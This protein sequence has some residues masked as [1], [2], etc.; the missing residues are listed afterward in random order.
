MDNQK[1]FS[2]T[3]IKDLLIIESLIRT[4]YESP[5]TARKIQDDVEKQWNRLFPNEPLEKN[6]GLKTIHKHVRD[7]NLLRGLYNIKA[8]TDNKL[9]YYNT[10]HLLTPAEV[11]VIGAAIYNITS[12]TDDE[13]KIIF[14]EI[15]SATNNAGYSIAYGFERQLSLENNPQ[16]K[17]SKVILPK[18]ERICKA[19]VEGKKITF[20]LKRN[21]ITD[22]ESQ[23]TASPYSILE[24]DNEIFLTAKVDSSPKP[25]DFR[26]TFMSKIEILA[27]DFNSDKKF[28][29]ARHLSGINKDA[30]QIELRISFP[31][32]LIE[33]VYKRFDKNKK[34]VCRPNGKKI[35]DEYQYVITITVGEDEN[36]YQW[37]RQH[38]DKV[39]VISPDNVKQSLKEQL[40]KALSTL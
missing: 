10:K 16:K 5:K 8:R 38:C 6:T 3:F 31:E 1:F 25:I 17:F 15:K 32:S 18:I 20:N 11:A 40:S 36:L 26:L 39:K 21:G 30:T 9:G 4:D 19:I 37:L 7:M 23:V 24:K 13:K 33:S 12:L 22:E 2:E 28:S 34:S 27:E 29:I 14:N 35:K